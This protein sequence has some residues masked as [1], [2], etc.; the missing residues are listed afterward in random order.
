MAPGCCGFAHR[1][2]QPCSHG[3]TGTTWH[4][5]A[6]HGTPGHPPRALESCCQGST[7][8]MHTRAVHTAS[9]RH[10]T[11]WRGAAWHGVARHSTAQHW[12]VISFGQERMRL[13]QGKLWHSQGRQLSCQAS[14]PSPARCHVPMPLMGSQHAPPAACHLAG[15]RG[16]DL[17]RCRGCSSSFWKQTKQKESIAQLWWPL[18]RGEGDHRRDSAEEVLASSSPSPVPPAAGG[19]RSPAR[20]HGVGEPFTRPR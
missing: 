9:P 7:C 16:T 19:L 5:T 20:G 17:C 18:R 10:G 15:H 12:A 11:A 13:L 4:G 2:Q 6:R 1:C 8:W 14:S 3:H